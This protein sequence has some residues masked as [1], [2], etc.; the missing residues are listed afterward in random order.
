MNHQKFKHY[1]TPYGLGVTAQFLR[2]LMN[3]QLFHLNSYL[4][5]IHVEIFTNESMY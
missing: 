2:V 3:L 5:K 1:W 4:L